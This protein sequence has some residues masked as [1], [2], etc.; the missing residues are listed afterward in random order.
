M[1]AL[2][3]TA[4]P[5]SPAQ[6]RSETAA[7]A[8]GGALTLIADRAE[9]E[10]VKEDML[11]YAFL[12]RYPSKYD[13]L[14]EIK[15]QVT[16]FLKERCGVSVNF[17]AEDTL[18]RLLADGLIRS[19]AEGNLDAIAPDEARAHLDMLWDR[20]LDVDSLDGAAASNASA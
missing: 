6:A 12:A 3:T 17:D 1:P 10:E 18:R 4:P 16:T 20:M 5:P 9:E 7:P 13:A 14:P 11:P 8:L 19:D 2:L 15:K